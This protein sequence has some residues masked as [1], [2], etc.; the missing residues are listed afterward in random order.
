[1]LPVNEIICGNCIDVMKEIDA[2]SI[3]LIFSDPPFNLGKDYGDTS[4][5]D[6]SFDKYIEWCD[7]WVKECCRILKPTGS[8]YIMNISENI[9]IFQRIFHDLGLRFK[10]MIAWKNSSL[11]VKNRYCLNFQPILFYTKSDKYTFNYGYESHISNAAMPWSRKNKGNL[12]I[13]QWNDIPFIA[14]GCMASKEAILEE[15]AKKKA[16]PCQM[17]LKLANRIIGFS[18]NENDLALDPFVGSGTFALSAKMMGRKYIGI[19]INSKY[20]DIAQKRI[21]DS[22]DND[23]FA[24]D[25]NEI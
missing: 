1:M 16:H 17:P 25:R 19:D 23:L 7:E 21:E 15:G 18:S 12:M 13:D 8:I 14:G 9:W 10:N 20:C 4:K 24:G 22:K 2:D 3:D 11:P 5:D 6:L